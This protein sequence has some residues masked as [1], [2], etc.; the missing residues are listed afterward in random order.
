VV[1]GFGDDPTNTLSDSTML[2][3]FLLMNVCVESRPCTRAIV[4]L[5]FLLVTVAHAAES[6]RSSYG[7]VSAQDFAAGLTPPTNGLSIRQDVWFYEGELRDSVFYGAVTADADLKAFGTTT[8]L[9]WYPGL[10][11]L[12]GRYGALLSFSVAEGEARSSVTVRRPG[13]PPATRLTDADRS[14]FSDTYFTPLSLGWSLGDWHIKW[15]ES[16][17]LPT[18]DYDASAGFNIGRNY[19]ALN[20][21]VGLTYRRGKTGPELNVRSGF[22]WNDENP[23]TDYRTGNEVYAD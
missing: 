21:S 8:R 9:S 17:I 14:G 13:V 7:S 20:S 15:L 5:L 1:V 23:D 12:G 2:H 3:T 11:I 6:A 4:C 19:Y 16:L 18:S 22:I 10:N